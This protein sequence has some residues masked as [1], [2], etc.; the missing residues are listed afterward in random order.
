MP[1][2]R[3]SKTALGGAVFKK[4]A[5][6]I[7]LAA[8]GIFAIYTIFALT[9]FRVIP[10]TDGVGIANYAIPVK[11]NTYPG[12]VVPAGSQIVVNT[13]SP[14]GEGIL[15]RAM[16]GFIPQKNLALVTVE[17][18]PFGKIDASENGVF[19]VD[20]SPIDGILPEGTDLEKTFLDKE[21]VV[22]CAEGECAEG[23]ILIIP[24]DNIYGIPV[25]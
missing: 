19:T 22:K 18:G 4:I 9:L 15:D 1:K 2:V 25:N 12:G 21:Y 14:Q 6:F 23:D 11:N 10:N 8:I 20:G 7:S 24:E 5:F 16:Q 17:A 13:Q 3:V